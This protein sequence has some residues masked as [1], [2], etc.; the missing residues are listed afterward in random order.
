MCRYASGVGA[1]RLA[2]HVETKGDSWASQ[3]LFLSPQYLGL[4]QASGDWTVNG[5]IYPVTQSQLEKQ[6]RLP[7]GAA[8]YGI[9]FIAA[10]VTPAP[11]SS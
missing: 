11:R 6:V 5:V 10:L 9:G 7:G 2:A 8:A 4:V 1:G 3:Q